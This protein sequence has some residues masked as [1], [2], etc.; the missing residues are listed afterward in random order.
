MMNT[1][2]EMKAAGTVVKENSVPTAGGRFRLDDVKTKVFPVLGLAVVVVLLSILTDGRLIAP[3]NFTA[4]VNECFIVMTACVGYAFLLMQGRFD[5]SISSN[6]ALSCACGAVAAQVNPALGMV[7]GILVGMSVGALNAF[8]HIKLRIDAFI[9]TLATSFVI[10][11]LV[12]LILGSGVIAAPMEMLAWNNVW[13]KVTIMVSVCVV[14]FIVFQHTPFGKR[15][16]A[17]GSNEEA[18]RQ[19]GIDIKKTTVVPFL[20]VGGLIGMLGV[21]SLIRTGTASNFSGGSVLIDVLAAILIGGMPITGGA[22]A[23]FRAVI[24][25]S[26]TMAFLTSGLSILGVGTYDSQLI[27]GIIFLACISISFDRKNLR[28]IK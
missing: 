23:R 11:G 7:V 13:V 5:F 17:I 1:V 22:G 12:A 10:S 2:K 6:M 19:A 27:K 9:A 16:R 14:G 4:L 21:F 15:S 3:T 25:G 20:M 8:M 26:L 18:A 28:V 24:L